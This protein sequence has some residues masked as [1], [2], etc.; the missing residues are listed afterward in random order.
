VNHNGDP[1]FAMQ[2]VDAAV[3]A[4]ADAVKFQTLK[5][6]SLISSAAPKADYQK[7]TTGAAEQQLEM[8]RRI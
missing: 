1:K 5:P 6:T 3:E 4:S 8:V 7:E 2:L